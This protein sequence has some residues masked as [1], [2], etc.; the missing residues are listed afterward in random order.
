MLGELVVH[1]ALVPEL[2]AVGDDDEVAA[3]AA[4]EVEGG[5]GEFGTNRG[6]QTGRLRFVVSLNAVF[7]A[8][9]HWGTRAESERNR[10]AQFTRLLIWSSLLSTWLLPETKQV[11]DAPLGLPHQS[12]VRTDADVRH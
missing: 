11:D 9:F 3:S 10:G 6:G 7:D 8:D 1:L 12:S 2:V 5:A 4:D